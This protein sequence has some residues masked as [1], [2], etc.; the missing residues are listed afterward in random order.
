MK[1]LYFMFFAVLLLCALIFLPGCGGSGGGSGGGAVTFTVSPMNA[2]DYCAVGPLGNFNPRMGHALPTDHGGF[3]FTENTAGV[4]YNVYAPA[5]GTIY[6]ITY[7]ESDWP[8]GSGQSGTYRDWMIKIKHNNDFYSYFGHMS[9]LEASILAQAGTL[10]PDVD[11]RVSIAVSAGQPVGICG[12]R[13]GVVNGMDW[14]VINYNAASKSFINT[15]RYGRMNYA[16]HFLDYCTSTLQGI[17]TP[18]LYDPE[19][20]PIVTRETVPLGGKID[21]DASGYLCGNWF[22]NSTSTS[23]A[24]NYEFNKQLAF[25]YDRF[26]PTKLRV[27]FGGPEG[28]I[29]SSTVSTPLGLYVTTYQVDGNSPDP[30]SVNA[31]S[32]EVTYLLHGMEI[33]NLQ[34]LEATLLVKI[35]DSS[36]V[37]VEGFSGHVSPSGF[38]SNAQ[39]YIR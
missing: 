33:D 1:K 16:E 27:T 10:L 28:V 7:T 8:A 3:I 18:L 14:Y 6:E 32:G 5:A 17:Y 2:G 12:G 30:A 4:Y 26:E 25:A 35:I 13:P 22:H 31:A 24:A 36:T 34:T 11:N 29:G 39:T 38:T 19:A 23:E 20:T 9:S 21:F 37:S 15:S